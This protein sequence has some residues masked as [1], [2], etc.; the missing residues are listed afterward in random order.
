MD[1][2]S[3]DMDS[4]RRLVRTLTKL[5]K[6]SN[7]VPQALMLDN[8]SIGEYIAQGGF[9]SVHK[10]TWKDHK[11]AV[12]IVRARKTNVEELAKVSASKM[13]IFKSA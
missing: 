10:G 5:S 6:S 2:G 7:E 4:K 11:V 8:V 1:Y 13:R 3:L 12:K 9:G